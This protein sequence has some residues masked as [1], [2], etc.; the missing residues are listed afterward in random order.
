MP[1]VTL[2][3]RTT[4]RSQNWGVRIAVCGRH[5]A[6]GLERSRFLLGRRRVALGL[7]V[8]GGDA[9]DERAEH[10]RHEVKGAEREEGRHDRVLG[11]AG[12]GGQERVRQRRRDQRSAAEAHDRQ[13]RGQP[14]TVGKPLDQRRDRRDV[15]DPQA[16]AAE[17]SVAGVDDP[18]LLG[19]HAERG[20][21]EA[22]RPAQAGGEHRLA[23]TDALDPRAEQGRRQAEHHDRDRKDHADR[24]ELGVE[25]L[26]Q[27]LLEHAEGVDLADAQ[28]HGKGGGRNQPAVERAR[29]D[30]ALAIQQ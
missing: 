22:Q 24:G 25:M 6:S 3:N 20:H 15:A 12:I 2:Q 4:Q 17:H 27:R 5:V 11:L 13:A 28:V 30:R 14:G 18:Q 23:R 1:A 10:H 7:P 8:V 29:R 16:D 21:H 9:H 26:H 19:R